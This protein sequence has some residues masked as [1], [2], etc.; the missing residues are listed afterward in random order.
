MPPLAPGSQSS[1]RHRHTRQEEFLYVLEG[2]PTLVDLQAWRE[3]DGKAPW[4]SLWGDGHYIV[5]VAYDAAN[6]YFMDPSLSGGYG[7]IPRAQ[8]EGLQTKR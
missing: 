3:D 1:F 8:F 5:L 2:E 4:S 7:Y 6:L